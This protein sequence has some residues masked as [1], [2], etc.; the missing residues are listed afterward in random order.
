MPESD[1]RLIRLKTARFETNSTDSSS[2]VVRTFM[3]VP[4]V[5]NTRERSPCVRVRY[6]SNTSPVQVKYIDKHS[7]KGAFFMPFWRW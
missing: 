2:Y 7:E 6:K 4:Q 3:S 1:L 5:S